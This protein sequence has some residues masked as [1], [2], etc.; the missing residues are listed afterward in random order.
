MPWD[1][2]GRERGSVIS[3]NIVWLA[4]IWQMAYCNY[5]GFSFEKLGNSQKEGVSGPKATSPQ[6]I[7]PP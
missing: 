3:V 2:S 6:L 1:I 4:G 7:S 5:D